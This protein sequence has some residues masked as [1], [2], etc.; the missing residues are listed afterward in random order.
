MKK[1]AIV[2]KTAETQVLTLFT[3]LEKVLYLFMV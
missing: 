2:D 1:N 3:F